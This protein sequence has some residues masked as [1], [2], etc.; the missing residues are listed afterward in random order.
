MRQHLARLLYASALAGCSLIYN[1]SNLDDKGRQ[2]DA[3]IADANPALLHIDEVKS[4]PLLEGAGQDGS[5]PQILVVY[6]G[7][8]IKDAMVTVAP[9]TQNANVTITLSNVSIADDGNSFAAVVT[10]N[11]MDT[12]GEAAGPIPLTITMTQAGAPAPVM[13]AWEL[14][15]LD[16]LVAAGMQAAP[17]A[18]KIFSHVKVTGDVVFTQGTAP[19]IVRAVGAIDISGKVTANAMGATPGAGGCAGGQPQMNGTC[20]GG[21]KPYGGGGGFAERGVDGAGAADSGGA[22]SGDAYIKVYDGAGEEANR[23]AGGAGGGNVTGGGGSGGGGGGTIEL[24][25]GGNITLGDVIEAIG[26][27]GGN[28]GLG[29][30]AGGGSGGAV[31]LRSGNT[32]QHATNVVLAGGDGGTGALGGSLGGKGS[33]GRW[34]YDALV[35]MGVAPATPAGKRGPMLARPQ[36][37]IFEMRTPTLSIAGTAGDSVKVIVTGPDGIGEEK[38]ITLQS[39]TQA[40]VPPELPIGLDTICVLV[41]NGRPSDDV[42]KNCIEVAFVP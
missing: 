27:V 25:A 3:A 31:V 32:L 39:A 38:T 18:G 41:P 26:G 35:T 30:G 24:T 9:T 6:G 4:G 19:A 42:A 20:Y 12:V 5:A 13:I 8:M 1:P 21:G 29:T 15:P 33:L 7:H 17:P 22:V 2:T 16:E 11:Y 34:R 40:F 37:P 10:A 36:N 23:G 14:R 28:S